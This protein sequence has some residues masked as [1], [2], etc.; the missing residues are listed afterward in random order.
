MIYGLSPVHNA[1]PRQRAG[2]VNDRTGSQSLH[3]RSPHH[4]TL[5]CSTVGR[6]EHCSGIE[7]ARISYFAG[8]PMTTPSIDTVLDFNF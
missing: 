6:A 2:I 1:L 8:L 5:G 3:L 4:G 7:C